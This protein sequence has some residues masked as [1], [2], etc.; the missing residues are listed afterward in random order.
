MLLASRVS[1]E[2]WTNF[3]HPQ[4]SNLGQDVNQSISFRFRLESPMKSLFI[5]QLSKKWPSYLLTWEKR[6]LAGWTMSS[7]G[8]MQKNSARSG[9]SS[10]LVSLTL[11]SSTVYS[12]RL[13]SVD[14]VIIEAKKPRIEKI[15]F[16]DRSC[17]FVLSC[18]T[19]GATSTVIH[20]NSDSF[21]RDEKC[22]FFRAKSFY[23]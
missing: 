1:R 3:T 14:T 22:R 6:R 8:Q 9:F 15:E 16:Q 4:S 5:D 18:K 17:A 23:S 19:I 10:S 13:G 11:P 2:R 7:S 21:Q 20:Q 12:M